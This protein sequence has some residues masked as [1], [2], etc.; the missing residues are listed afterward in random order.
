MYLT[1]KRLDVRRFR[2][3]L[4]GLNMSSTDPEVLKEYIQQIVDDSY[5]EAE[6][7]FEELTGV[8]YAK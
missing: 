8:E 7:S 5:Y 2:S 3:M 6:I 1:V 4:E